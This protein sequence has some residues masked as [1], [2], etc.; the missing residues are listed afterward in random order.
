MAE[1]HGLS[2]DIRGSYQ[3]WG[4]HFWMPDVAA[5]T[6]EVERNGGD[7]T[8]AYDG[9]AGQMALVRDPDGAAFFIRGA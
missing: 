6:V 9:S 1:I 7:I 3:F 2:D 4:I 5:A 8:Y